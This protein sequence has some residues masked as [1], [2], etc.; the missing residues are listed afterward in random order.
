M[1]KGRRK[2][3]TMADVAAAAGVSVTTVSHVI[4]QT[5]SISA[6]TRDRV[7]QAVTA[8][9]YRTPASAELNQGRRII[10]VFTPEISNEFYARSIQA[11]IDEA[12][13][14]DYAVM[15]CSLEHR[16]RAE[17]SYI[18]SLLQ[19]G[20]QGLIFFG[21]ADADERQ[22][23]SALK[24]AP[25]VLG[26]RRLPNAPVDAVG[27]DN[28]DAMRRV[29]ARLARAGYS[30]LG[31]VSED[32]IMS[33]TRDRFLGFRLGLEENGL[34]LEK[35]W[36]FQRPSLRLRKTD[37]AY[38]L[39]L[40]LLDSGASL[41]QVL[42]CSSDLIAIGILAAL[43]A[44]GYRVPK[45]VGIVGFDNISL[46]AYCDPPLTTVAQDMEVLGRT[47][48]RALLGRM[49]E[50]GRAPQETRLQAKLIIRDSVRL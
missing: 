15:L 47:C 1:E 4:N 5:A 50:P 9:G 18:R 7:L 19:C 41:P 43:R 38:R 49:A 27:V 42:L 34:S 2:A 46:A 6:D 8:L 22:I 10:G 36:V 30:R 14:H 21:G 12:G 16:H 20:I 29:V 37:E 13:A 31:Y 44:R 25:V 11:I 17:V 39:F 48:F 33:N 32:L 28:T 40:E 26:D 3:V 35:K 23:L 45:D 24:R